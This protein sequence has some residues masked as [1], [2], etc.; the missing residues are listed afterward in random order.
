MT[1]ALVAGVLVVATLNAVSGLL[2]GWLWY[3][4]EP[5]DRRA[6]SAFWVLLRVGQGSAL[7]LALAVGSLAAAGKHSSDQPL[8]PLCA[9][10]PR[11]GVRRRAATRRI[12]ADDPRQTRS[13]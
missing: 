10:A 5:T 7:L 8:L 3:R 13:P 12:G 6:L 11:G 1:E 9:A 2:G 4:G